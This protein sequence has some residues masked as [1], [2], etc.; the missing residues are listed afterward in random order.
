[1]CDGDVRRG[2]GR[3][4][5]SEGKVKGR[6]EETNFAMVKYERGRFRF[7]CGGKGKEKHGVSRR[8]GEEKGEK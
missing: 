5:G 2:R 4:R 1:M 7:V 6:G 3:E 8:E